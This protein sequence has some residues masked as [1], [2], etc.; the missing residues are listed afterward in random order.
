MFEPTSRYFAVETATLEVKDA[1]GKMRRIAYKRRRF[2]PSPEGQTTLLEHR[3]AQGERLD[4]LTARYLGN[5]T[6]FWRV[7]D[8]NLVLRPEELEEVGRR[9]L[10]TQPT[11]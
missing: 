10:I 11:L 4:N 9:I 8:A 3:V 1:E 7:C 5:P 2:I 6:E